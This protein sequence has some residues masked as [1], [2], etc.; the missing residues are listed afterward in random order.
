[1]GEQ[2]RLANARE[3]MEQAMANEEP[4]QAL[5]VEE[6]DAIQERPTPETVANEQVTEQPEVEP[7][8]EIVPDDHVEP[9]DVD[10]KSVV[11]ERSSED[12]TAALE[13]YS[14][15]QQHQQK[16]EE[17]QQQQQHSA[18]I[19]A[20]I[21]NLVM[22]QGPQGAADFLSRMYGVQGQ[23][24]QQPGI[25]TQ[26][27]QAPAV[28]QQLQ[29]EYGDEVPQWA[30]SLLQQQQ[31]QQQQMAAFQ[32]AQASAAVQREIDKAMATDQ[33]ASVRDI[34]IFRNSIEDAVRQQVF[35]DPTANL[36]NVGAKVNALMQQ[37]HAAVAQLQGSLAPDPTAHLASRVR[38]QKTAAPSSRGGKGA[39]P[40][41]PQETQKRFNTATQGGRVEARQ[42]ARRRLTALMGPQQ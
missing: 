32:Q 7:E 26:Q 37:Q 29:E 20:T 41:T 24:P 30:Q 2:E 38:T 3:Q 33:F 31:Q 34:P 9:A 16:L 14:Q 11:G 17:L 28:H 5:E 42:D 18:G 15:Q 19:Q 1:M 8:P 12:V 35:T 23:A 25:P 13:Y 6:Q 39:V 36:Q 21:E 40:V 10:W 4:T 27:Q 22:T